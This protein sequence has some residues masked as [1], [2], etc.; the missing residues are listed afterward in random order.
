MQVPSARADLVLQLFDAY[1]ERVYAFLR[2]STAPEIADDLAQ[3]V[4]VR[5]LQHPQ[6]EELTI[7]VSYLIKIAHNLM[8]RRYARATRLRELLAERRSNEVFEVRAPVVVDATLL[9]AA[10]G[11][12]SG[13]EQTA[14]RLIVCEGKSY[15]HAAESLGVSVTTV[16]NWKHRGLVKMRKLLVE[17]HDASLETA[18][19]TAYRAG[20][21]EPVSEVRD[22]PRQVRVGPKRRWNSGGWS[23]AGGSVA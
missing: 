4:F 19:P 21:A 10:L 17:G 23:V 8:R 2:K 7:S 14:V 6:L 16:N 13:D 18:P 22:N 20:R 9:D 11:L 15:Q 5:L 12:L 1:Y 3:E